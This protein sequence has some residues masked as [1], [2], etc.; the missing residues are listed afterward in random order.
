MIECLKIED[1][2]INEMFRPYMPSL[3]IG[4]FRSLE[5][6]Q[7]QEKIEHKLRSHPKYIIDILEKDRETKQRVFDRLRKCGGVKFYR[8]L[9]MSNPVIQYVKKE[10]EEK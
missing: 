4:E 6:C 8:Y 9:D 5:Y 1:F 3:L 7:E 2:V 10:L